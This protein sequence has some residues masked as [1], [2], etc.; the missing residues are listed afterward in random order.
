MGCSPAKNKT[1]ENKPDT[2]DLP[3]ITL[4]MIT[5]ERVMANTLPG[6]SIFI[7]FGPGCDHCQRQAEDMHRQ[8]DTFKNYSLYFIATNPIPEIAHFAETYKLQGYPNIYFA[9]ADGPEVMRVMGPLGVPTIYIYSGERSLV[10]RF[11]NETKVDEIAKF[12]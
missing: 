5:G 12:L 6:N 2:N 7:F 11:V 1:E 9:Q 3:A 10:K 4:V 8:L